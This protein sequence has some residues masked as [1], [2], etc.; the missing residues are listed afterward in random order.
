MY[1]GAHVSTSGGVDKAPANGRDLGCQAIQV[2]TR[3][4]MQWRARALAKKEVAA[5]QQGMAASKIMVAVAHD[6][7]LINL[8]SPEGEVLR[9]SLE[10]FADEMERCEQ[11]GIP[12]LV[13]HPGSHVGTGEAAGLKRIV[14]SI[15]RV[16]NQKNGYATQVLLETT[17]GQGSNL[18]YRF[19]QLASILAE[20]EATDRVGICVDT[21]HVFAAG[22]DLR[23]RSTYDFTFEQLHRVIGLK[24]I[25]AFH[26]NDSKKGL[27]SRIDRHENI[28]KGELG[29]DP[30][31]FLLNDTRFEGLP[32]LL[33]TPGGDEAYRRDLETLRSLIH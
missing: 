25:K 13:A 22:Y 28:G 9:K 21:C 11:L 10:A 15:N 24:K 29:L 26:L 23:T 7:Y 33:E 4:Q 17:A 16:L 32:M 1:L 8:G 3:N 18:G 19:E 30:F 12:Y 5:F 6:S 2:F 14:E 31:R 27:G 20:I